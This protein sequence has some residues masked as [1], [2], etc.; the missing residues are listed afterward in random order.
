MNSLSQISSSKYLFKVPASTFLQYS[1]LIASVILGAHHAQH[2]KYLHTKDPQCK[3]QSRVFWHLKKLKNDPSNKSALKLLK[4]KVFAVLDDLDLPLSGPYNLENVVPKLCEY[5]D[6]VIRILDRG[7]TRV[8]YTSAIEQSGKRAEINLL[9][10]A[11]EDDDKKRLHLIV[12][13]NYYVKAF[14]HI[15]C[16]ICNRVLNRKTHKCTYVQ[17]CYSCNRYKVN[18]DQE[19][20]ETAYTQTLYCKPVPDQWKN[21]EKCEIVARSHHCSKL[22]KT[23]ASSRCR[24]KRKCPLCNRIYQHVKNREHNCEKDTF[25][26]V[27][28]QYCSDSPL[29]PHYCELRKQKAPTYYPPLATWDLESKKAEKYPNMCINCLRNERY[30]LEN[31]KKV[32]SQLSQEEKISL[33]CDEHKDSDPDQKSFHQGKIGL[34][35][36]FVSY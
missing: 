23:K 28:Y 36:F 18:A 19:L 10:T 34:F 15:F 17:N 14:G 30:Y 13:L 29:D 32:W 33:M 24:A 1:S 5:F 26:K 16:H 9:L 2:L 3:I 22:H 4:N 20:F 7:G 35:Y 27:C 6:V 11:Q 25:C 21:C 31:V 8:M 12:N